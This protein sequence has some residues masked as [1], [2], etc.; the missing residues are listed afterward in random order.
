MNAG[1]RGMPTP[2]RSRSPTTNHYNNHAYLDHNYC[3]I[4]ER[5]SIDEYPSYGG[6]PTRG[7][8]PITPRTTPAGADVGEPPRKSFSM[9]MKGLGLPGTRKASGR[10]SDADELQAPH[11]HDMNA[12]FYDEIRRSNASPLHV[13]FSLAGNVQVPEGE[14]YYGDGGESA[15]RARPPPADESYLDEYMDLEMG[16]DMNPPE[17]IYLQFEDV[18]YKVVI[19]KPTKWGCSWGN[20]G[21]EKEILHGITGSVGAGEMLAMMGPSGSGKTTLLNL[22]GGRRTNPQW[23]SGS[24]LYNNVP[25]T[26]NLKRRIGFVTQDDVLFPHLTVMETL[27]F[28]ALLRLP[29]GFSREKKVERAR[30]VLA[31]LGLVRC[32]DTIIGNQFLRGVSGGERKRVCIGQEILVN[33]SLLFLDEPTSGLDSTTALRIIRLLQNLA[34]QGRAVMATI[35]QPSSRAFHMFDKLILLSEGYPTYFGKARGALTYFDSIGFIPRIP[36]NPA[37]F[38]LD[39]CSGNTSDMSL[40]PNIEQKKLQP[41]SEKHNSTQA[42]PMTLLA[43]DV[44]KYLVDCCE[45]QISTWDRTKSLQNQ[46]LHQNLKELQAVVSEKRQWA[47]SW[48][49]QFIILFIRGFKER[50]HEYFSWMRVLQMVSSALLAGCLWW[51]SKPDNILDQE[52]LLFF[53]GVFWGYFPLFT[54]IF[55]FPLERPILAKERATDM[56]RLSAYFM[57]RTLSDLPIELFLA[58]TFVLILY[59]M[60]NLRHSFLAFIYTTLAVCLDVVASQGVGFCIGAAV[61]DAQKASTY[62]SVFVLAFMLAGGYFVQHIPMFIGWIKY[63]SFQAHTYKILLHIQYSN[64]IKTKLTGGLEQ[65]VLALVIMVIGYRILAYIALRRMKISA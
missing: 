57:A 4:E 44:K 52:G 39:L 10:L 8:G 54:A 12:G 61:M 5:R 15:P 60:T 14:L 13:P 64:R 38:L 49:D 21:V 25:Y 6:T 46:K 24:I 2:D 59:F 17:S 32:A 30:A 33:P 50:R 43:K 42:S 19:Q 63:I 58:V 9:M 35:H 41:I 40:P 11:M 20:G 45:Q 34:H 62:A 1:S 16:K 23:V 53:M 37:D 29:N 56:Y 3:W 36:M 51:R 7:G 22:L 31:Q 26:K 65:S 27:I 28:S 47:T 48:W 18:K 55:T